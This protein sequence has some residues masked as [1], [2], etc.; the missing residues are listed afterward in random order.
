MLSSVSFIK[1]ALQ[2]LHNLRQKFRLSNPFIGQHRG[3]KLHS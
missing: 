3:A 2:I 1:D